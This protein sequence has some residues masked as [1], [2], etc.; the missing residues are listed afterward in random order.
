MRSSGSSSSNWDGVNTGPAADNGLC[1]FEVHVLLALVLCLA[2][3]SGLITMT[4]ALRGSSRRRSDPA[5]QHEY[6][7]SQRWVRSGAEALWN[8]ASA[9]LPNFWPRLDAPA[10]RRSRGCAQNRSIRRCRARNAL[11]PIG[12]DL[13]GQRRCLAGCDDC[14]IFVLP[15]LADVRNSSAISRSSCGI[16]VGRPWF[17]SSRAGKSPR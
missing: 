7:R 1:R 4:E 9:C 5:P 14:A 10:W 15:A 6:S 16:W 8:T 17:L 3:S 2:F 12:V 11:W 13:G